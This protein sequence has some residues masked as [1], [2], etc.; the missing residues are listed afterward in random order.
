MLPALVGIAIIVASATLLWWLLPRNGVLNRLATAPV[1]E[2]VLPLS[3]VGG[4]AV[5]LC[6]VVLAH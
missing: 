3:I 4:F 5:G 1:L 2:S 6:L